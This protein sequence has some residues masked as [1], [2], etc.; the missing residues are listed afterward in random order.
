VLGLTYKAGT[1]TLRRSSSVDLCRWLHAQG[2]VVQTH[3]P[4]VSELPDELRPV[5]RLAATPGEALDGADLAVV[6][7]DWPEFRAIG[8]G[9]FR[10]RMKKPRIVDPSHFLAKE[11]GDAEGITY[12]ATGRAA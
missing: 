4:A 7:T 3:D 5:L 11:L 12:I 6:A 9:E 2:V 8:A 10:S 1:S